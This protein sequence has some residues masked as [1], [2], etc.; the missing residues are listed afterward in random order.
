MIIPLSLVPTYS[1]GTQTLQI[2]EISPYPLSL[3][4]LD[5]TEVSPIVP[6]YMINDNS[7]HQLLRWACQMLMAWVVNC[8]VNP[9]GWVPVGLV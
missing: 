7:T 5:S 2:R 3:S 8:S 4:K 1:L 6:V 9:Q